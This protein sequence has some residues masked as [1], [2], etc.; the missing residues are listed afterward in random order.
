MVGNN[1]IIEENIETSAVSYFNGRE[2]SPNIHIG[3]NTIIR[4]NSHITSAF[5]IFRKWS[6]DSSGGI[7]YR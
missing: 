3:D 2:Y 1:T 6:F 5:N 7:N 4:H